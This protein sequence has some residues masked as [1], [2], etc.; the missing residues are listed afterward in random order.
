MNTLKIAMSCVVLCGTGTV[1]AAQELRL[2]DVGQNCAGAFVASPVTT[3]DVP[4]RVDNNAG[5]NIF[6]AWLN[7]QGNAEI[8]DNLAPGEMIEITSRPHHRWVVMDGALNCHYQMT[9]GTTPEYFN[10]Q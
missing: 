7:S 4:M 10:I 9:L 3:G 5:E 8:Y 1:L 2:S 6:V